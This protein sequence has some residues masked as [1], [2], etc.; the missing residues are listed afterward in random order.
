MSKCRIIKEIRG[1]KAVD[2]AGV[3][4]VRV[5]GL[6]DVKDFDPFLMLDSFDSVDAADYIEGFPMHPHRGIETITYLIEGEIEHE[7]SLGNRGVISSGETQWMTSGSGILHQEMPQKAERMLGLQLWLNMPQGKKMAEPAYLSITK[8]MIGTK[9]VGSNTVKVLSGRY[10]EVAGVEPKHVPATIYDVHLLKGEE[11]ELPVNKE[12]TVF[13]FLIDG[14][15]YIEDK[16]IPSKTAV[17]FDKGDSI[18]LL[19]PKDSESRI[20]FF[21]ATPLHE[22]IAWG[23][24]VVMNTQEELNHAFEELRKGTF[25][26]H[27]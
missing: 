27:K 4:L 20:I 21:S 9:E 1:Q 25:I 11:I 16:R 2:G 6:N 19:A 24:P 15:A 7:D 8:D 14:D 10:E 23:G 18:S 26:K 12:E 5:L 17:L 3:H 22:P 13:V